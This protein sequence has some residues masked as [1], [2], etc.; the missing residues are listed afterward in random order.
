MMHRADAPVRTARAAR[1]GTLALLFAGVSIAQQGRD[2]A[3][4]EPA[5]TRAEVRESVTA[6]LD[7]EHQDDELLAAACKDV[8]AAGAVGLEVVGPML[9]ELDPD[10]LDAR[11][12]ALR[13]LGRQVVI[14][15]IQNELDRG[16]VFVG[17]YD[18]LAKLQP[19]ASELMFE[20]LVRTP[21]WYPLTHRTRLVA[22][23]RDLQKRPPSTERLDAIDAVIEDEREPSD[24]R[25]ALA[26]MM[27][28]WG[29]KDAA[30]DFV[31]KL[32]AD[33]A[34]GDGED[35]VE[36]TLRLADYLT[37]LRDYRAAA[38]AHRTAQVLAEQADVQL[39]PVAWYAA[40]CVHALLGEQERAFEALERCARLHASP[41]LDKSLRLERELFEEDPEIASLREQPRF[42]ELLRLAFGE[43][44]DAKEQDAGK[45]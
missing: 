19:F 29:K 36:A 22:P 24:L 31:R 13:E 10:A 38:N 34:E 30:Q 25:M 21:N 32:Q 15:F 16:M 6:W 44:K 8:V 20:L 41:H 9:A 28:Q 12:K 26:A 17:Q 5:P 23:L 42:A 2:D 3:D 11:S 4:P 14:G 45:R 18:A 7:S 40:A 35:R 33:T 39:R 1:L 27:W 37:L 43:P